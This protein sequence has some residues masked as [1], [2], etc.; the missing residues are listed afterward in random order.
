MLFHVPE[1]GLHTTDYSFGR[2]FAHR[3]AFL[4]R[5]KMSEWVCKPC[6]D[7]NR[8]SVCRMPVERIGWPEEDEFR[9]FKRRGDVGRRSVNTHKQAPFADNCGAQEEVYLARQVENP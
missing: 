7:D 2:Q 4:A 8:R 9:P 5:R 3:E 1:G 6:A